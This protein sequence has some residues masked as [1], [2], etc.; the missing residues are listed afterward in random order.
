MHPST[1]DARQIFREVSIFAKP[2]VVRSIFELLVTVVPFALMWA[3]TWAAVAHAFWPGMIL[4]IPAG[5]L[6]LRLFIIQHDCGHGSLFPNRATN[7]WIGRALSVLTLTPYDSWRRS[8]AKHHATSGNLSKRGTGDVDTFTV[9]EYQQL[10]P[11]KRLLYRLYRNPIVFLLIGPAY[12]FLLRHRFPLGLAT[13]SWRAWLSTLATNAAI[14]LLA[15]MLIWQMGI[16][17]FLT[18]H[19]PIALI[20]ATAGV[21]LFYVQHQFEH[22]I[23]DAEEVWNFHEAALRGSSFYDLPPVLNWFTGNIGIHHIH[24]L[25]SRI[26]FYRLPQVLRAYPELAV[27]GRLGL[28]QS[29]STMRLKLWNEEERRLCSYAAKPEAG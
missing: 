14:G 20:A 15:A 27:I 7:D 22:T 24:H 5:G 3:L 2:N 6:L 23:W 4:A 19:I 10:S 16:L 29:L 17:Q 18:V 11:R 9:A 1:V 13:G 21:W 8:H 25:S 26:P 12:T 28:G